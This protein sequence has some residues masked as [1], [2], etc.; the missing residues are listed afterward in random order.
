[1]SKS[2]I[3]EKVRVPKLRPPEPTPKERDAWQHFLAM[4]QELQ[5]EG[6]E[7]S[8]IVRSELER[9]VAKGNPLAI[10]LQRLIDAASFK[11]RAAEDQPLP[12]PTPRRISRLQW[13]RP[14]QTSDRK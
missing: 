10:S 13:G 14:K 6:A 7:M 11:P 8:P 9:L 3:I 2:S 1:M 4:A 5:G 12:P